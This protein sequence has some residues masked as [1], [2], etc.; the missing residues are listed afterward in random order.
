MENSNSRLPLII[1]VLALLGAGYFFFKSCQKKPNQRGGETE[2]TS[3]APQD[4]MGTPVSKPS[5]TPY[6]PLNLET[7]QPQTTEVN[8]EE[9]AERQT[10]SK[11]MEEM[12]DCL[13]MSR[14][15]FGDNN[16]VTVDTM[17]NQVSGDF[18]SPVGQGDRWYSWKLTTPGGEERLL[19]LDYFEDELGNPQREMHY[20]VLRSE[21]DVIPMDL[22]PDKSLNPPDDF[23]RKTLG[24]GKIS[25]SERARYS[26]FPSGERVDFVEKNG[27]LAEIEVTRGEHFFRCDNVKDKESCHCVREE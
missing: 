12:R 8:P 13:E 7:P 9:V 18:G 22:P 15:S 6:P 2:E 20:F 17:T 26:V 14:A 5:P 11:I 24:D 3:E 10:F 4:S 1:V 21:T 25:Y 23:I 16:P 19:R 27:K